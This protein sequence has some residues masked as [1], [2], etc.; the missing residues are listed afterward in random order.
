MDLE[1]EALIAQQGSIAAGDFVRQNVANNSSRPQYK[2]LP[3]I[4][5][6]AE[7]WKYIMRREMQEVIP[8][9]YLGPY[10]AASKSKLSHLKECGITHIVCIRHLVERNVIRPMHD[11]HF[12]YLVLEMGE[13]SNVSLIPYCNRVI[14]FI[15]GCFEAG[16]KILIHSNSGINRSAALVAGYIMA[17]YGV[18]VR[19]ALAFVQKK[20]FAANPNGWFIEQLKEY[21]AVCQA[22]HVEHPLP[23]DGET[24]RPPARKRKM[25]DISDDNVKF[26]DNGNVDM[27]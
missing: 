27:N 26:D 20:R 7:Y 8:G 5:E 1:A 11:G 15:D 22:M 10:A 13:D 6:D 21:E 12:V 19:K 3:D 24:S 18:S 17:T 14:K 4:D 2:D 9:L 16:G 23:Q 25:V